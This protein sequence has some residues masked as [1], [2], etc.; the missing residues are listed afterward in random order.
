VYL[1]GNEPS[2]VAGRFAPEKSLGLA[3]MFISGQTLMKKPALIF[4]KNTVG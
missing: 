3:T 4:Y 2:A 1:S